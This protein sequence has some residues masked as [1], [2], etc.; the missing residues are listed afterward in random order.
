MAYV[1][2]TPYFETSAVAASSHAGLKEFATFLNGTHA[3]QTNLAAWQCID[4]YDGTTREQPT[5]GSFDNLTAANKWRADQGVPPQNS[6][7]VFQAPSG[8]DVTERF[9]VYV[10]MTTFTAVFFGVFM[11]NDWSVGA[12]TDANPT[13]PATSLG[14]PPFTGGMDGTIVNHTDYLWQAVVDQGT[15]LIRTVPTVAGAPDML[16][17]GDLKSDNPQSLDPRPFVISQNPAASG[18]EGIYLHVA[19]SD[20]T[21]IINTNDEV[22][23]SQGMEDAQDQDATV[24]RPLSTVACYANEVNDRYRKGKFR[25]SAAI[26]RHT[27]TA[28]NTERVTCGE[29]ASD[30]DFEIWGK[31][32][33]AVAQIVVRY[34][35]GTALDS[36]ETLVPSTIPDTL[37]P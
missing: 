1:T 19:V 23:Q 13:I 7:A 11:L 8:G 28:D 16:Y 5:S 21:T 31:G 29:G 10:E 27:R 17:I 2:P 12:G 34:A 25:L 9:Q 32:A 20:D 35:P 15:I 33:T 30:F 26:S 24:A 36:H 18:W 6:W 3:T 14:V 22:E 37:E 4:C